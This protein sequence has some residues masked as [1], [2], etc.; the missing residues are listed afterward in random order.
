MRWKVTVAAAVVVLAVGCAAVPLSPLWVE[1]WY[2]TGLYPSIQ[3]TLTPLSNVVPF[4]LLDVLIVVAALLVGRMLWRSVGAARRTGRAAPLLWTVA[5]LGVAASA[6]YLV[7][8][9]FWGFNYRRIAM[10]DRLVVTDGTVSSAAVVSLGMEAVSQ[11]NALHASAHAV[12]WPAQEWSDARLRG[13]FAATQALLS[14]APP[15][16][17]GRPKRSLLGIYFRSASIDGMVDPFA[18]EVITNPDLLPWERPFVVAHEWAHLAG[19]A[20]EAEAN[21]AGWLTCVR[22]DAPA[23][24]SGWLFLYWQIAGELPRAEGAGL[25]AAL[26]AGPR[27]DVNAIIERIRRAELPFLRTASW[28]VYDHDLRANHVEEGVRSYGEVVNLI[29]RAKFD[30][31]WVPVRRAGQP[32]SR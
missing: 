18:L 28:R 24:Y 27:S 32:P 14:D 2:S 26:A 9:F 29:L 15:A 4:A 13:A 22:S 7:F 1:Q 17:P 6:L 5:R 8:L 11:L 20:H 12:G 16:R 3:R 25:T 30:A 21:F 19:Y 23:Q 10:A 31:G